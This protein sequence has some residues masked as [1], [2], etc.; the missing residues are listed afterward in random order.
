MHLCDILGSE[1]PS[2]AVIQA[3]MSESQCV[4]QIVMLQQFHLEISMGFEPITSVSREGPAY[5]QFHSVIDFIESHILLEDISDMWPLFVY[6]SSNLD[7]IQYSISQWPVMN[8]M[9]IGAET[10]VPS[11][12][13]CA[14]SM[15]P[16]DVLKVK[17]TYHVTDYAACD[18]SIF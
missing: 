2:W 6:F 13:A 5:F 9:K 15:K 1:C 7:K 11:L 16:Y 4:M 17:S 18:L 8:F 12:Q 3:Y 14:C 10:V